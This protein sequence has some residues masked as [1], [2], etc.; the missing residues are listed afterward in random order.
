MNGPSSLGIRAMP[1]V[2]LALSGCETRSAVIEFEAFKR[3]CKVNTLD[4]CFVARTEREA[5]FRTFFDPVEGFDFAWGTRATLRLEQAAGGGLVE[6]ERTWRVEEVIDEKDA[7]PGDR[8]LFPIPVAEQDGT[9]ALS[10]DADADAGTLLDGRAFV[11]A[12]PEVCDD[13]SPVLSDRRGTLTVT[14]AYADPLSA[15]LIAVDATFR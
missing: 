3:P 15:P 12:T 14:F 13:L 10:L 11:C 4:L 7:S 8:F 1:L 9:F 6:V 2:V 5:A